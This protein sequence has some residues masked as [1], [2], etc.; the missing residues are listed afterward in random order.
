MPIALQVNDSLGLLHLHDHD[1]CHPWSR[2][3][4][5]LLLKGQEI[6]DLL[7]TSRSA[8]PLA[9]LKLLWHHPF[10]SLTAVGFLK[11]S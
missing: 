4:R 9:S 1:Y 10:D 2:Q 3:S 11:S 6:G 8:P 5:L 7:T